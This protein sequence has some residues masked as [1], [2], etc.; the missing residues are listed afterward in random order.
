MENELHIINKHNKPTV[1]LGMSG[2]VDSSVAAI[3]LQKE[4][5]YVKGITFELCGSPESSKQ[6]LALASSVAKDI[7]IEW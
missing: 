3:L 1:N 2:G 4:G 6:S 5:Y 7:G